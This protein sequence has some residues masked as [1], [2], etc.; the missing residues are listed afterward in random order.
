MGEGRQNFRRQSRMNT[1]MSATSRLASVLI[2][3]L[4]LSLA[5]TAAYS[6]PYPSKPIR[7]VVPLAPGGGNDTLARYLSKYLTESLGQS[8]VVENRS[9]GGGLAGGEFAA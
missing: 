4:G 8:V 9:G 1:C 6:Q 2:M 3:T 5:G 7:V